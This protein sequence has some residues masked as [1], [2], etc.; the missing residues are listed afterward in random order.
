MNAAEATL[1]ASAADSQ[2]GLW[3]LALFLLGLA[4]MAWLTVRETSQYETRAMIRNLR[5]RSR[6]RIPAREQ[7]PLLSRFHLFVRG[8]FRGRDFAELV[9]GNSFE[10]QETY[11]ARLRREID[12]LAGKDVYHGAKEQLKPPSRPTAE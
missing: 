10:A 8:A 2:A 4:T 12:K 6:G 9:Q 5:K 3:L 1:T 11:Q 7:L